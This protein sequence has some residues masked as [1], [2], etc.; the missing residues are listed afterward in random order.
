M[1]ILFCFRGGQKGIEPSAFPAKF[2]IDWVKY[3]QKR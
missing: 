2:E 3:Y 1:G